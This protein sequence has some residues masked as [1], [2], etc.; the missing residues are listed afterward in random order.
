MLFLYTDSRPD[1]HLTYVSTQ[2]SLIPL[3]LNLNIDFYEQHLISHAE[4]QSKELWAL[5]IL[6]FSQLG[7]DDP[8]GNKNCNSLKLLHRAGKN[9]TEEIGE[10]LQPAVELLTDIIRRLEL[11]GKKSEVETACP[12]NE[13]EAFWE[14]NWAYSF[15]RWRYTGKN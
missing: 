1:H 6:V 10:S 13:L 12:D 15:S 5:W 11:K 3:F 4:I 9:F 8:E 7:G 14:R 2:L